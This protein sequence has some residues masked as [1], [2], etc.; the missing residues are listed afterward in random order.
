ML[1]VNEEL[2]ILQGEFDFTRSILLEFPSAE[3]AM[4]WLTSPEYQEIANHP[5]EA[6]KCDYDKKA[7]SKWTRRAIDKIELRPFPKSYLQILGLF[8]LRDQ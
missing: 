8:T 6:S 4:A 7:G 2:T 3:Q 5:L 1:S